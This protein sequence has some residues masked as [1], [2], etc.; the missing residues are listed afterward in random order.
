LVDRARL[1]ARL[2]QHEA[3]LRDWDRSLA[4]GGVPV[5]VPRHRLERMAA[6]ARAGQVAQALADSEK[7]L[8]EFGEDKFHGAY[9]RLQAAAV[10][11]LASR[12]A[13]HDA[14]VPEAERG[15]EAERH[16]SRAVELLHQA[17]QR[18]CERFVIEQN[19]DFES[20]RSRPDFQKV[21]AEAGMS[22]G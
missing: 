3:A 15:R 18:G 12:A 5:M 6:V 21:L 17:V 19:D 16:A 10:H 20:L 7:F 8:A 2:G 4:L 14:A 22:L 1:R 13:L 11:A 9:C